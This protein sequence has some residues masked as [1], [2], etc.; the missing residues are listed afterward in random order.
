MDR[1]RGMCLSMIATKERG[2]AHAHQDRGRQHERESTGNSAACHAPSRSRLAGRRGQPFSKPV[3][4]KSAIVEF[5]DAFKHALSISRRRAYVQNL[6]YDCC[7][8]LQVL[9]S[10]LP[11]TCEINPVGFCYLTVPK[12]KELWCKEMQ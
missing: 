6:R 1:H 7:H 4:S 12:R 5:V 11:R 9:D 10:V 2:L 8:E 3:F